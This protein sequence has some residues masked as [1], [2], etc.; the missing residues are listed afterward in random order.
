MADEF[1][2]SGVSPF[3]FQHIKKWRLYQE[4]DNVL[5]TIY[6]IQLSAVY[7]SRSIIVTFKDVSAVTIRDME[8]LRICLMGFLILERSRK[9]CTLWKNG[10]SRR[11]A[12]AVGNMRWRQL[13]RGGESA[14]LKN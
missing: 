5:G 2:I 4:A 11:S 3:M 10:K 9:V 8:T 6:T 1:S 14:C 12:F 7:H 13:N